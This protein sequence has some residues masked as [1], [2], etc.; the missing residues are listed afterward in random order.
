[1]EKAASLHPA[2]SRLSIGPQK[3]H[4][5]NVG[6]VLGKN[7]ATPVSFVL[8]WTKDGCAT[9][10]ERTV[11]TGGTGTAIVLAHRL[12]IPV[13]NLG[14]QG[15]YENFV[16]FVL[17]AARIFHVDATAPDLSSVFV[18]G[19]NLAGRHGKGAAKLA[20]E[21][22]GAETGVG[23]GLMIKS[24]AI[25]TKDIALKTLPLPQVKKSVEAFIAFAKQHQDVPFFVTRI[26]C[27]LA[28]YSNADI[29]P[30]FALAPSNCSFA[31][32]W[33]PWIGVNKKQT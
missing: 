18:F 30:M 10:Q 1:M 33:E 8:C 15:A 26:G 20:K 17:R 12:G 19:S 14:A 9:E 24:Y 23:E 25:P 7:L 6:Q 31:K 32:E 22:F 2:W 3:L 4:A 28:G 16:D 27:G 5:R 13:F 29:A 11:K 21:N